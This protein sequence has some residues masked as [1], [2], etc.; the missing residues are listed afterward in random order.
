M[1][2]LPSLSDQRRRENEVHAVAER[3]IFDKHIRPRV[4]SAIIAEHRERP[5]GHHSDELERV[6]IHL[7]KHHGTMSGKYILV[8]TIPHE[9]W[10]VARITGIPKE[11][12]QL[13][14]QPYSDRDEAEHGIFL[15]RLRDAGLIEEES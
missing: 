4:T 11:L 5:I 8:C 10:R 12:P 3:I 1:P 9:E 14:D 15:M 7:R 2:T 13:L 6:L